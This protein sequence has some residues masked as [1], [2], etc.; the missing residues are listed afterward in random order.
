MK[1]KNQFGAVSVFFGVTGLLSAIAVTEAERWRKPGVGY[2]LNWMDRLGLVRVPDPKQVPEWRPLGPFDLTDQL[3][4][5]WVLVYSVCFAIWAMLVALWAEHRC[6]ESLSQSL[7]FILGALALHIH[8]FQYSMSALLFG[9][10]L[11]ALVRRGQRPNPS[12]ERT[13]PGKPGTASHLKR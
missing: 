4:L 5:K 9:G 2:L 6:E 12:I 11:L 8:G 13:S 3:A 1:P 10:L 7:G